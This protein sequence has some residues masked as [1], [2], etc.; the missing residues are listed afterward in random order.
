[1]ALQNLALVS[2]QDTIAENSDCPTLMTLH[3]VKG[4]EFNRVFQ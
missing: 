1:M 2:D 4:L 3:A